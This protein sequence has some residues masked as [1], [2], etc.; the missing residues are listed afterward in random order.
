VSAEEVW[1]QEYSLGGELSGRA[2]EELE[3]K[4]NFV[5]GV[6]AE[7]REQSVRVHARAGDQNAIAAI[8]EILGR[9]LGRK[10]KR[11]KVVW[12][13]PTS[14]GTNQSDVYAELLARGDVVEEGSGLLSFRGVVDALLHYF[15]SLFVRSTVRFQA[16]AES[17][18]GL[19]PAKILERCGHFEA[20]PQHLCFVSH[21]AENPL[22]YDGFASD[23]QRH[24]GG[25]E[26]ARYFQPSGNVLSPSVC[27][28][29]YLTRERA[30]IPQPGVC[31]TAVGKCFRH[32]AANVRGLERMSE[33]TMREI[34]FIGAREY[35]DRCREQTIELAKEWAVE[36]GLSGHIEAA[37]DPFFT[38]GARD[39][40][41]YQRGFEL[42]YELRL[43]LPFERRTVAVASMNIHEEFF[44]RQFAI[45]VEGGG[46]ASTACMGIGVDRWV[47]AFLAQYGLDQA[48]WPEFVRRFVNDWRGRGSNEKN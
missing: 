11:N 9:T 48:R 41:R 10:S 30:S 18:P 43:S 23:W 15:D 20:F 44:G 47:Y 32:E 42:K 27:Y 21:T 29:S 24:Q 28:H 12:E 13:H 36:H 37:N 8:H 45:E 17:Y 38:Q 34:V 39:R 1:V 16:T 2:R 6:R 19:I 31:V 26:M 7:W 40:E 5:E 3:Y 33:F 25:P 14:G 46:V 22:L 35:T 4:L